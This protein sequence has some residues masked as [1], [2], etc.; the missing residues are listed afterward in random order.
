MDS[1][2]LEVINTDAYKFLEEDTALYDV[3][4]VDLPDPNNE[5]LNKLYTDL[6]YR[7]CKNHLT[8]TGVMTVQSTSPYYAGKAYWCINK[9]IEK[10]GF[11][12]TPYHVQVPSFGDWG[13][14]LAT[15]EEVLVEDIRLKVET[16]FLQQN[17]LSGIFVFGKDEI[18]DKDKLYAN[19]LSRPQLL[20]Y[21]MEAEKQWD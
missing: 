16:K 21:Y 14:Q 17:Q 10:E 13:F 6:F 19:T 1:E 20:T 9:T 7:L 15:R 8:Q 4:I 18:V 5:S 3:I 11:Y 12:V 2:K